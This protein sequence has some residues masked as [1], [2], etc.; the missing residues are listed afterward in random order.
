[1]N[2]LPEKFILTIRPKEY[3]KQGISHCGVYSLKGIL[4]AYGKDDKENPEDY[5]ISHIKHI[6]GVVWNMEVF[7][8]IFLSY[9]ISVEARS[10]KDIS[11]D[12]RLKILKEILSKNIPVMIRI[13][14]GYLQNGRYSNFKGKIIGHWITLWGYN[15][16]KKVFYVYDS[17]VP[18]NHYDKDIPTGNKKRTYF[19][20]LRDWRG[21]LIPPWFQS[22]LYIEIRSVK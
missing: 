16:E 20:M 19:E 6:T 15:N 13:G 3:L 5:H 14:N 12:Q 10:A 22:Y 21:A 9:G 1:M 4:S 8:K 2:T 7:K 11:P 18:K 17:C